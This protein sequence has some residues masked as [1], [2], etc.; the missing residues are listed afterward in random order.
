MSAVESQASIG[1]V[2]PTQQDQLMV[3]DPTGTF[4]FRFRHES[5]KENWVEAI[6]L[7]LVPT[8]LAAVAGFKARHTP[9]PDL[10]GSQR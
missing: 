2:H 10:P 9:R 7:P 5:L 3:F 6:T 4:Q 8:A 1:W